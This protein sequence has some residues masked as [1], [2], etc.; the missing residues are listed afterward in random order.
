MVGGLGKDLGSSL[1]FHA[2]L[3][4]GNNSLGKPSSPQELRGHLQSQQQQQF[5]PPPTHRPSLPLSIQD[6]TPFSTYSAIQQPHISSADRKFALPAGLGGVPEHGGYPSHAPP[7]ILPQNNHEVPGLPPPQQFYGS[8]NGNN[9]LQLGGGGGLYGS[10]QESGYGSMPGG[11]GSNGGA[12]PYSST[13][14]ASGSREGYASSGGIT[15]LGL[16]TRREIAADRGGYVRASYSSET[17]A[18]GLGVGPVGMTAAAGASSVTTGAVAGEGASLEEISTIF[19]VGF[20]EDMLEREFQNM[21]VFSVGFEAATLK[22]PAST[23]AA[24]ERDRELATAAALSA[25]VG[26]SSGLKQVPIVPSGLVGPSGL[27][28]SSQV[29]FQDPFGGMLDGGA[30]EDAFGNLPLDGPGSALAQAL[31]RDAAGSPAGT[32]K[33]IIGFAKFRTRAQALDARDILSGKKVDAEKGCILKA[34]MAK[35]NLHTKRGISNELAGIPGGPSFPLSSL[36]SATLGRLANA[37]NLN[38]AVLAELARQSAAQQAQASQQSTTQDRDARTQSAAFEAFHS[39]PSYSASTGM[40]ERE[41]S[42]NST[43]GASYARSSVSGG[44]PTNG[45]EYYDEGTSPTLTSAAYYNLPRPDPPRQGYG[46]QDRSSPPDYPSELAHS[47]TSSSSGPQSSPHLRGAILQL[48]YSGNSMMQQLD[49]V[50]SSD[51]QQQQQQRTLALA[52][53]SAQPR[54]YPSSTQYPSSDSGYASENRERSSI[55]PVNYNQSQS[56]YQ[57]FSSSPLGNPASRM[58][59]ISGPGLSSIPTSPPMG[60]SHSNNGIPRTQNPA[61]MNAP[62]KCATPSALLA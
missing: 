27:G 55:P 37:S 9:S 45:R 56:L 10:D 21:F 38:P 29:A 46:Q 14:S 16:Q 19:V 17:A 62:K 30:Y 31:G 32:R 60:P 23:V 25:A 36:D 18:R 43:G 48:A 2:R 1:F 28:L 59:N 53:L 5:Y 50:S 26:A 35:K 24:R 52:S 6:P 20:P 7:L 40:R 51:P 15:G 42:V 57:G 61:D 44:F 39:I 49:E 33:Q 8:G 11:G 12:N 3:Q 13:M 41:H 47:P 22:I 34:E 54:P 4:Q 58:G